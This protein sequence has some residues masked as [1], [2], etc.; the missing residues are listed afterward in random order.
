MGFGGYVLRLCID[1][2][3]GEISI[4]IKSAQYPIMIGWYRR[5]CM[6]KPVLGNRAVDCQKLGSH[7]LV[8]LNSNVCTVIV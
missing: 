6:V 1:T 7:H 5:A 4:A 2:I 3:V 8:A